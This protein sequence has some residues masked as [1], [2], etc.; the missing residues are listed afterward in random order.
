MKHIIKKVSNF[1]GAN[2]KEVKTDMQDAIGAAWNDPAGREAQL[3]LF[4]EGKPS[5]EQFIKRVA[6]CIQQQLSDTGIKV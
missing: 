1:Y 6:E 4:P 5:P 3:R 2:S